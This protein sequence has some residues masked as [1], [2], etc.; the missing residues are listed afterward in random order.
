MVSPL[1]PHSPATN[2]PRTPT[3]WGQWPTHVHL[4]HG[5]PAPLLRAHQGPQQ[6]D[7]QAMARSQSL[8]M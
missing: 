2:A 5:V 6:T 7:L 8:S 3:V 4:H 1:Q